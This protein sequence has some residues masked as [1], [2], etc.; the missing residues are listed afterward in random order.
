MQEQTNIS[1]SIAFFDFDGTI[2]DRDI[3][4]DFI[5]YRLRKGLSLWKIAR[6]K[7]VLAAYVLKLMDNETAKEQ[8][9][10]ILFKGESL[11]RFQ[12]TVDAYYQ[13]CFSK[14][15]R[16]AALEKIQWHKSMQHQ[17]VIVSANFHWLIQPFATAQGIACISTEAALEQ[18]VITG[19]FA[20]PNCY[21]EE[22]VR[23]IQAVINNLSS[24]E[25]IYAYGDSKGDHA[26]LQIA[27]N[28][29][30]KAF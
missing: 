3:F 21:G 28:P 27:T 13:A 26:M 12:Q 4:F 24:Y 15:I 5:F 2:T 8:I 1:N 23:R 9:F 19:K 7:P 6:A 18:G 30:Y 29:F 25:Q 11:A 10:G 22:K 17:V 20:T 16:P 14:R